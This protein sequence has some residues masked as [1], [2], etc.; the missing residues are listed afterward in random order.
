MHRKTALAALAALAALVVPASASAHVT[1]Q[2][3]QATAGAFTVEDIRVPTE[4]DN[5]STTKVDV[6]LPPGFTTVSYQPVPGWSAKVTK[7]KL[8]QP[9]KTDDGLVTEQVSGITWT[10]AAGSKGIAPGQFTDFPISVQVPDKAGQKLT[11]KALQTYSNGE[12]VRWIGA[13]DADQPAPQLEV[14]PAAA[15]AAG[16]RAVATKTASAASSAGGSG[17]DGDGTGLAIAALA[18]GLA[19]LGVGAAGFAKARAAGRSAAA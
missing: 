10:R 6:Q 9:V 19:G 1:V 4:R 14:L 16:H 11:F 7:Q 2:P 8:A 5:A 17:G 15:A 12:V 3:K 13:P 18:V